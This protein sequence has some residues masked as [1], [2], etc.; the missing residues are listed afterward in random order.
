MVRGF[1]FYQVLTSQTS[2]DASASTRGLWKDSRDRSRGAESFWL[3]NL[4]RIERN[5]S[6]HN[7]E[8]YLKVTFSALSLYLFVNIYIYIYIYILS[9]LDVFAHNKCILAKPLKQR[10]SLSLVTIPP[11]MLVFPSNTCVFCV[12]ACVCVC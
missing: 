11:S 12:C 2:A 4:K 6:C 7:K 5:A 10:V 8:R 9:G 3:M 1:I